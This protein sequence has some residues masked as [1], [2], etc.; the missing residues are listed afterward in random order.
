MNHSKHI[1]KEIEEHD[2]MTYH[3]FQP[4]AVVREALAK[5]HIF[6]YPSICKKHRA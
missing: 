2:G 4:N 6:A 1:F 5:S 3:G